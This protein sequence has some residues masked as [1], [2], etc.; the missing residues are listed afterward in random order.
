[1]EA[2][3]KITIWGCRGSITTPGA[4]TI[5]HGGEST[6]LEVR[7]DDGQLIIIDAGSGIRRLGRMLAGDQSVSRIK[8]LLT[9]S[10][11]DH[12]AGFPFFQPAYFSRF[13]II[14]C[15]G[16]QAQKPVL[17]Y[18]MHQM[19]PPYFPVDFKHLK[20]KFA[21][22]CRCDNGQCN[23]H[24]PEGGRALRCDSIPLNHPDGG[25]GF[26]LT[27]PGGAFVF[28]TDNEIRHDHPGGRARQDYVEFCRGA[29]L[30]FHDAQY[31]EEEYARTRGWGHSTF[32]DAVDL[33][34]D[35][36]VA[37]LGLFHHDPDRGDDALDA[38][39]DRCR[40]YIREKGSK[41]DCFACAD[42]MSF[43]V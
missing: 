23:H 43:A 12:L 4:E 38:E 19:E 21:P 13:T 3:M 10:H 33:A 8:L 25:T 14:P 37:R 7:G 34:L 41:L 24:L 27:G 2:R 18:F 16:A 28:L 17:D 9:H 11:W 5:R 31:T 6:C 15:G 39:V 30:L 35:A 32:Q 40:A 26:K 42:G 1:M 29:S 36:G 22:G 20:A